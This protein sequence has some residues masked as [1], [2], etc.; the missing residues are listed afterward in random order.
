MRRLEASQE[1]DTQSVPEAVF[2]YIPQHVIIWYIL[3]GKCIENNK[4]LVY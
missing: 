3:L 4:I 1:Q 2:F